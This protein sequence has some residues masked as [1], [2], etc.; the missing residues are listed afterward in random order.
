MFQLRGP[1][2]SVHH[3][4]AFLRDISLLYPACAGLGAGWLLE[5]T[6]P[7]ASLDPQF[8]LSVSALLCTGIPGR[9]LQPLSPQIPGVQPPTASQILEDWRS[10]TLR[11]SAIPTKRDESTIKTMLASLGVFRSWDSGDAGEGAKLD[12]EAPPSVMSEARLNWPLR[13]HAALFEALKGKQESNTAAT[14]DA[15]TKG[16]KILECHRAAIQQ[17]L[18]H[19]VTDT[20]VHSLQMLLRTVIASVH[21]NFAIC[22]SLAQG[23]T[24]SADFTA[25]LDRARDYV[26]AQ[27][28]RG[29]RP[30]VSLPERIADYWLAVFESLLRYHRCWL[31]LDALDSQ[32]DVATSV[33][34]LATLVASFDCLASQFERH[35]AKAHGLVEPEYLEFLPETQHHCK[36]GSILAKGAT[37]YVNRGDSS[38]AREHQ[39]LLLSLTELN[40]GL[41]QLQSSVAQR[42]RLSN[43]LERYADAC[44][45]LQYNRHQSGLESLR[46]DAALAGRSYGEAL[47]CLPYTADNQLLR[48]VIQRK[49]WM[50]MLLAAQEEAPG[51]F[52]ESLSQDS[53][54]PKSAELLLETLD[55]AVDEIRMVIVNNAE[56]SDDIATR[57]ERLLSALKQR[58]KLVSRLLE[59]A[60]DHTGSTRFARDER[61]IVRWLCNIL[62]LDRWLREHTT[63]P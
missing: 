27:I 10:R 26:S 28:P 9:D 54:I 44:L 55:L 45:F 19:K 40:A 63:G 29:E 38:H 31:Q 35:A 24:I 60:V 23:P 37:L 41:R 20:Y 22:K 18:Q 50:A 11:H 49:R 21:V 39:K 14:V 30:D 7:H 59:R 5:K 43:G 6:R 51:D 8:L 12:S 17:N 52:P 33:D 46:A 36:L 25:E 47:K 58:S 4:R 42:Q 32:L 2:M 16:Q 56:G 62:S 3:R 15:C 13:L 61:M 48:L 53:P 1:V 57:S 34:S